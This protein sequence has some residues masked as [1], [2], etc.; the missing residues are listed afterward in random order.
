MQLRDLSETS[1]AQRLAGAGVGIDFG[2]ARARI[3]SDVEA[4]PGLLNKLYGAF[5]AVDPDGFFDATGVLRHGRGVRRYLNPQIQFI[6]DGKPLFYPFPAS[7]HFPL[8]EWG[9]NYL[10]AERLNF[11]LLLH[12]GVVE[13]EGKG[14]VLPALPGSGKSTLTA[15]VS[16]RGFRLLSDEF[17][18]V[19]ISDGKLLPLLKAVGLKNDSIDVI[20]RFAPEAVIGPRFHKTRK[21]TVAHLAPMADAVAGRHTPADP[22]LVVFPRYMPTARLKIERVMKSR[23]FGRLAVNSFNYEMLGP[24]GFDTVVRLVRA[25]DCYQLEY[26]DLDEAIRGLKDL[27]R[28]RS[29]PESMH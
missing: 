23:A 21:G 11:H 19:R 27:V 16:L 1:L 22:A 26:S 2:A 24:P 4:L 18:V 8:L 17:G 9:C 6:V 5:E 20:Q 29:S 7:A 28:G 3:R 25:C 12:S 15:A 10:F 13:F 14:I